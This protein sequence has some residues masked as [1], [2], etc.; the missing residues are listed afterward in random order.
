MLSEIKQDKHIAGEVVDFI[1]MECGNCGIPF[2]VPTRWRN[3]KINSHGSFSCPNGCSRIFVAKSEAEKL[4]EQLDNVLKEKS[5]REEELTNKWLDALGEKQKLSKQLKRV[6]KGVC[7][8]C[9]RSFI[10]LQRHMESK[11]PDK[12]SK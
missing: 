7:P 10:N 6:H 2:F 3:N 11:H 9:N 12:I 5:N 4:K 8:C 1:Q